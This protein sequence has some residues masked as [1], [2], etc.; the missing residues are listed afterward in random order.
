MK[1]IFF[2]LALLCIVCKT[3]HFDD[4]PFEHE[5]GLYILTEENFDEFVVDHDFSLVLF[6]IG[7][8]SKYELLKDEY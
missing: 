8:Y 5:D 1:K 2:I 7:G 6:Y 3:S 4:S